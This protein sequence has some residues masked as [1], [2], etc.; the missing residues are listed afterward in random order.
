M[1]IELHIDELETERRWNYLK[2]HRGIEPVLGRFLSMR[3]DDTFVWL[4][5]PAHAPEPPAGL[6][7]RSTVRK[8]R[9]AIGTTVTEPHALARLADSPV[10]ELRQYRLNPG[11]RT[12]FATFLRDR[13]LET[14][15]RLGMSVHGPFEALDDDDVLVWFRG[16]PDLLERDRRKAA[17]YQS[18]Y[19]LEELQD[20]AFS[21]IADY[22]NV[23]LLTPVA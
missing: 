23:L 13:T 2:W 10:L 9:P 5:E 17:F 14:H 1:E 18:A 3:N 19:W 11:T 6:L 4:Q 7:R 22:S 15:L 12:R 20:E 16:F 8:L 21:M